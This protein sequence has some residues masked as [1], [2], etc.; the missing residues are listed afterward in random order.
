LKDESII[1]TQPIIILYIKQNRSWSVMTI[2]VWL[3]S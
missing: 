3:K 1:D 2:L